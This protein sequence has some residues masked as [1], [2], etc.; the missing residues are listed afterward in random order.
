V[1]SYSLWRSKLKGNP[2]IIGKPID[3]DGYPTPV[4]GVLP[5]GFRDFA[6]HAQ[7]Y[8]P[9]GW[10]SGIPGFAARDNHPG[11]LVL[12]RLRPGV[13]L[14]AAQ[15]EM[16]TI[17]ARLG[18]QYPKS[19]GGERANVW[20]IF[21]FYFRS[22]ESLLL[23]LFAAVG[24]VL[25]L[26]CANV[27]TLLLARTGLRQRELGVRAALGAS[28]WR[29]IRQLLSESLMLSALGAGIGLLFAFGGKKLLVGLQPG[30]VPRTQTPVLNAAVLVFTLSAAVLTTLLFGLAPSWQTS[31]LDVSRSLNEY[32][33]NA[34][35][36]V[37]QRRLQSAL[38]G[39]EIAVGLVVVV[40]AVLVIRSL[41][42]TLAVN[43]G[44]DA[45]HVL[46][47]GVKIPSLEVSP[48]YELNFVSRAL[49]RVSHLPGVRFAG[50]AMNPPLRGLHWT[51][52]YLPEGQPAPPPTE[53]PNTA[54]NMVTPDYFRAIGTPLV[55][56][57]FFTDSDDDNSVPVVIINQTMARRIAANGTV[58]GRQIRVRY[59]AH[60]LV[61]IVGVVPDIKQYGL[62]AN[63]WPEVYVPFA[64]MPV[65]FMTLM[66][67]TSGDPSSLERAAVSAVHR[68]D[69]DMPV[70]PVVLLSAYISDSLR[71]SRFTAWVLG[72]FG[73]LAIL[74]AAVG[75]YGV[76]NCGV[77]QRVHEIGLRIAL[78][79]K[80]RDILWL[81]LG[82]GTLAAALGAV[83]GLAG[84]LASTR[85]LGSLLFDVTPT[86]PAT[87]ALATAL[88]LIVTLIACFV[89]ARRAMRVDPMVA[90]R[91]E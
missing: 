6:G 72:A 87:F 74:L 52:P 25:L 81:T 22:A 70:S 36:P 44:F 13:S 49:D 88:L 73:A 77:S 37:S 67:R 11:I 51:S 80:P 90:L 75:A 63:D 58:V 8:G 29:L 84:A 42:A 10:M 3:L 69:P 5:R 35:R 40:S 16:D 14:K 60:P 1:I 12:A 47:L 79:A 15:T 91:Y 18:K 66:V 59:A 9:I 55:A 34:S 27:A 86:D 64:Q 32:S 50:A 17:M 43:P 20:P 7:L 23:P 56:G 48:T 82:Q 68:V 53:W 33:S 46:T 28:R 78:G 65:S 45:N 61:Q 54:L 89:P 41:A 62:T 2:A 24:L 57:R 31:R 76:V 71:R 19:D 21:T 39:C 83:F 38:L 85:L 26:A 30:I 4:V